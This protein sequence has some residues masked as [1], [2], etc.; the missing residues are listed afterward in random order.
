MFQ[1]TRIKS[2]HI[3][4]A[5]NRADKS[6]KSAQLTTLS[7]SISLPEQHKRRIRL[8]Q[9]EEPGGQSRKTTHHTTT[10]SDVR[11]KKISDN[12]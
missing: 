7:S 6:E 3:L 4:T 10:Y 12:P 9:L 8:T 1:E 5:A 2:E 11:V